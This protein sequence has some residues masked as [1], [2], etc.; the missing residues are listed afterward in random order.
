M[1]PEHVYA[2]TWPGSSV[3]RA[4]RVVLLRW[5]LSHKRRPIPDSEI[6]RRADE[7]RWQL[8]FGAF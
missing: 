2:V 3:Q 7:V 5:L 6:E 1:K 8:K 4:N